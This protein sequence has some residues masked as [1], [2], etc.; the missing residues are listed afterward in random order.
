[1][2]KKGKKNNSLN[3]LFTVCAF[4]LALVAFILLL[5]TPALTWKTVLGNGTIKG[6]T[7]IFGGEVDNINY[8]PSWAGLLSFIFIT[9]ALL[10][11]C[12]ICVMSLLKKKLSIAGLLKFVAAALLIVAGVFVFFEI[13]AFEAANGSGTATLFG[14]KLAE[15]VITG[16]WITAGIVSIVAGAGVIAGEFISK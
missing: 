16:G 4:V 12:L 7:A 10:G 13:P 3:L 11:L 8:N 9:V 2:A 6:I 14:N 15:Y 5:A 1:M